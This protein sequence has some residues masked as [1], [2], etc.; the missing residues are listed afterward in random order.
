MTR[1][2]T[3]DVDELAAELA[4]DRA[5]EEV[6][7]A[8]ELARDRAKARHGRDR[9]DVAAAERLADLERAEREAAARADADLARMY[10]EAKERGERTRIAAHMARSGEARALR[11]ERLRGLNLRVLVPVLIGFA[12]WSTAGVHHGAARLMGIDSGAAMWW[13]LWLLEPVLIGAVV[14]VIVARARLA[15]SG[16]T[17]AGDGERI[18]AGCLGTS[19]VLNAVAAVPETAPAGGWTAGAALALVGAMLAHII[20]PVGAAATAH[21]IGVV[22]ASIAAAD[23][24]HD[25]RGVP[26]PLLADMELRISGR[27]DSAAESAP[28]S[29]S[30]RP[31]VAWPVPVG[32]RVLL[33]LTAR[34][35]AASESARRSVPD[36]AGQPG[37]EAPR[38]TGPAAPGTRSRKRSGARADKGSRVPAVV[39]KSTSPRALSDDELADRLSALIA[40]GDVDADASVRAVQSALGIGFDRAKRVRALLDSRPVPGQLSVMAP[41]GAAA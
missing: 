29:A 9:A 15:A 38:S 39:R 27:V 10:R 4:R 37:S 3:L 23:P 14:W 41:E 40:A 22:D 28:E 35:E 13:A 34:P 31:Q 30:E 18:A 7:R 24:W 32:G 26:V 17:L 33:P 6:R 2:T 19:I 8:D 12:A 1:K 36:Q 11:L 21:L 20:G 16:G 25:E 5:A